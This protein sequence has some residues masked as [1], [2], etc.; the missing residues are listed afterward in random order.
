MGLCLERER[1]GEGGER[2]RERV[3]WLA[4]TGGTCIARIAAA[5]AYGWGKEGSGER[6]VCLVDGGFVHGETW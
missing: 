1:G 2:E 3:G 6:S 5:I 4:I